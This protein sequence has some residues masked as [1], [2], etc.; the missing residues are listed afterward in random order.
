MTGSG[1]AADGERALG[2]SVDLLI[3]AHQRGEEELAAGVRLAWEIEPRE[4][5]ARVYTAPEQCAVLVV[6]DVLTGGEVLPGFELPLA[7]LFAQL[8]A[9][10]DAG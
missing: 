10:G 7:E 1:E 3:G 9:R 5:I 2:D 6:G 4:R 8:D